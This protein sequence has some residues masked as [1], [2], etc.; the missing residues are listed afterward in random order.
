[1]QKIITLCKK[2]KHVRIPK[3]LSWYTAA[4]VCTLLMGFVGFSVISRYLGPT[5]LGLFSFAQN[6]LA[7]FLSCVNGLELYYTWHIAKSDEKIKEMKG[8]FGHK[9]HLMLTVMA[10]SVCSALIILPL[11][12]AL[13]C[14]VISLPLFL[15][16]CTAFTVYSN[17][18]GNAK[19]YSQSQILAAVIL[20]IARVAFVWMEAKLV[21]IVLLSSL[22]LI[23]TSIF[24]AAHYLSRK[25]WYETFKEYKFPTYLS[26]AKL[27]VR[28]RYTILVFIAWQLILRADQLILATFAGAYTLG[29]YSA[30]TKIAEVPN[31][32]AG[33]LYI[34]TIPKFGLQIKDEAGAIQ[35]EESFYKKYKK[36]ILT[37]L[38]VSSVIALGTII[39][40]PLAIHILYGNEFIESVS[41]LR[42]YALSIP[43]LFLL[44]FFFSL[45][46]SMGRYKMQAAVFLIGLLINVVLIKIGYKLADVQ[47]VAAASFVAYSLLVVAFSYLYKRT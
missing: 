27:L 26:T 25:D 28:I 15:H 37:Y 41:I 23:L 24:I 5:S 9:L 47:G 7:V 45:Y 29:V 33:I 19:I 13:L 30:A 10:L 12:V 3:A 21:Y 40:A 18:E 38:G 11:D 34:Y 43:P 6:F 44:Y 16:S 2:I 22:D 17:A 20:L 1:M 32:I 39:F 8:F 42:I 14:I 36:L 35:V 4:Q 46:S 31:F